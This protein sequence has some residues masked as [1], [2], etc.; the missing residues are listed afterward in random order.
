MQKLNSKQIELIDDYLKTLNL[1]HYEERLEII[2]H[3]ASHIENEFNK[4]SEAKFY[5]VFYDY[6]AEHKV[7]IRKNSKKVRR[8][9]TQRVFKRILKN[10]FH[11]LVFFIA[12]AFFFIYRQLPLEPYNDSLAP[13]WLA[14]A[15]GSAIAL[16]LFFMHLD[17]KKHF[18]IGK[19]NSIALFVLFYPLLFK[20]WIDFMS[21]GDQVLMG[22]VFWFGTAVVFTSI[23][24]SSDYKRRFNLV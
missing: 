22:G 15:I 23:K 4:N 6:L 11:P 7:D 14:S 16:K 10:I 5:D 9:A 2:D 20:P 19:L 1:T 13:V 17:Y 12:L 18:K 21:I 8:L 24:V 3:I